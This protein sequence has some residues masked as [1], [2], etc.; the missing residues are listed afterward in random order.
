MT[1]AVARV[2]LKNAF[3]PALYAVEL[4]PDLVRFIFDGNVS[5]S[6]NVQEATNSIILHSK[7]LLIPSASF[8]TSEKKTIN[9]SQI[10]FNITDTT[11]EFI[12]PEPIPAGEGVLTIPFVGTLN[13][14]M[15]GFYRSSYTDINGVKKIMA[16]TQFEPL[17]ARR[18][19]PCID[20]PAVKVWFHSHTTYF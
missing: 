14:Q 20:E 19:L 5:I 8:S 7:E 11:V 15:A 17:D 3:V 18:A 9:A 6:G 12:F 10:K 4:S 2:I 16:S 13:N 1:E